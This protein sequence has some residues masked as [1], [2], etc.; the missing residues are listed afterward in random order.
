L[1]ASFLVF[2][3]GKPKKLPD[4][5]CS[6]ADNEI[7][8]ERSDL[9]LRWTTRRYTLISPTPPWDFVVAACF[10]CLHR[11]SIQPTILTSA[12]G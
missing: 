2:L 8:L 5:I 7:D 12:R 11:F 6:F 1:Q 3:P 9:F 10:F 4:E